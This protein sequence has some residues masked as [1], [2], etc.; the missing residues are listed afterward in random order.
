M[1]GTGGAYRRWPV[2][3]ASASGSNWRGVCVAGMLL[4]FSGRCALVLEAH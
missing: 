4:S 1:N 2:V 3:A